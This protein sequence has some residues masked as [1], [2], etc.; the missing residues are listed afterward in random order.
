NKKG[1]KTGPINLGRLLETRSLNKTP[2]EAH[3]MNVTNNAGDSSGSTK[4]LREEWNSLQNQGQWNKTQDI[5]ANKLLN[6]PETAS[7]SISPQP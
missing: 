7:I 1:V 2:N 6:A 4:N 5:E 3:L